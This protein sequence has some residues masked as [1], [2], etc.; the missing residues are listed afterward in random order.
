MQRKY[1]KKG[2]VT[3][4]SM[5]KLVWLNSWN[6]CSEMFR[7]TAALKF[8][9]KHA[10]WRPLLSMCTTCIWNVT[11]D[12]FHHIFYS[13]TFEITCNPNP[14]RGTTVIR[15][16]LSY[17][18]RR[19]HLTNINSN[20]LLN[21][22]IYDAQALSINFSESIFQNLASNDTLFILSPSRQFFSLLYTPTTFPELN[23]YQIWW[24]SIETPLRQNSPSKSW[25]YLR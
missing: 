23:N 21:A 3:C 2:L 24:L 25:K 9:G 17:R 11:E 6:S 5:Q 14:T 15:H 18:F 1:C 13:E 16:L 8:L 22:L 7:K 4:K 19:Q 12:R 10:W 20:L